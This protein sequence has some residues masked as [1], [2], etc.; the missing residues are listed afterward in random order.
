M[1]KFCDEGQGRGKDGGKD[2]I[3]KTEVVNDGD[4]TVQGKE[5]GQEDSDISDMKH[6][7]KNEGALALSKSE[8]QERILKC[9]WFSGFLVHL[10][11][12]SRLFW[13]VTTSGGCSIYKFTG[14]RIPLA[15]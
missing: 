13:E 1:A 7:Q 12:G 15:C 6:K 9:I 3:P 14:R 8:F 2:E 11:S 5:I 10:S 4:V